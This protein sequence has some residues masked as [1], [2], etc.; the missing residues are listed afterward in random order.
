M[1]EGKQQIEIAPE[2]IFDGDVASLLSDIYSAY[3]QDFRQYSVASLQRRLHRA[4]VAMQIGT[5]RQ[6]GA[7]IFSSTKNFAE[8]VQHLTVP[9]STMFRDPDYFAALRERVLPLLNTHSS[10]KIWVAG[11]STGEE[12]YSLAILLREAN[13]LDR[14][15]IYATDINRSSLAQAA[16]GIFRLDQIAEYTDNYQKS[17]GTLSFSTYYHAAYGN[18]VFDKTLRKNII[19]AEH[20]LATDGIFSDVHFVSCRNVLIYFQNDLKNSIFRLFHEALC[21]NGFLGIGSGETLS[22]SQY[23]D[24]FDICDQVSRIY[25]KNDKS[26]DAARSSIE[27]LRSA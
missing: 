18:A 23:V 2:S 27:Q 7:Y 11:C 25:Q 1:R 24:N 4:M 21:Q 14:T 20:C 6:L 26:L 5:L 8:L 19:F 3:R 12:V 10:L 15:I 9:V 13:M 17:G 16:R 22:Y